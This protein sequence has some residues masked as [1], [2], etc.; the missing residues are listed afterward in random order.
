[1]TTTEFI[2]NYQSYIDKIEPIVSPELKPKIVTLRKFDIQNHFICLSV[3]SI[4]E[5]EAIGFVWS[6]ML[7]Q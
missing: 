1:M 4:S 3:K 7:A 5:Y 6:L 2:E